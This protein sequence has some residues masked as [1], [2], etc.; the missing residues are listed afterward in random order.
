MPNRIT[1]SDVA[2]QAGV[3]LM[4]VSRVLNQRGDVSPETRQR[5]MEVVERL[6]F[7]PS[8]IARSLAT[9][10]TRTIGL[11]VPDI[12]NPY[13]SG[14]AHG[15]AEIA[16]AE[17]F[18][19][20]LCDCEEEPERELEMVNVLVEKRVDGVI[21]AAPRLDSQRLIPSLATH[22]KAIL[23]N[24]QFDDPRLSNVIGYVVNDDE[25]GGRIATELL[26]THGHKT[27]GFLAGPKASYGSI[28]RMSGYQNALAQAGV[29]Y[30]EKLIENCAPTV[31]G[32]REAALKLLGSHPELTSLFCFNDL[33]AIGAIHACAELGRQVPGDLAIVGY[34]DIP[35]ATWV[36]PPLTTCRVNVEEMG[37]LA[38]QLLISH[39][40]K[41]P[42]G[43]QNIVLRPAII[44]RASA[45]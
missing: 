33:V 2:R 15:V 27:V 6:G 5:V 41:C 43:C 1:M 17:G 8:S 45:P 35:M 20:L 39:L 34:D 11:V 10:R 37:K 3:S 22:R 9:Q 31:K 28:R 14:M 16:Y 32:G 7:R 36:K 23:I 4:T 44:Q 29:S 21:V 25:E 12:S 18:S 38:M 13:F 24:R 40:E 30:D 19:V 42:E 26:L